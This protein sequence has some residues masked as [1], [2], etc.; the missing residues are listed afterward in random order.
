MLS[1][2]TPEAPPVFETGMWY[3]PPDP[4]TQ[5]IEIQLLDAVLCA[6]SR[7]AAGECGADE[8]SAAIKGLTEFVLDGKLPADL[9]PE[10]SAGH[11]KAAA[12]G[13][14]AG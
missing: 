1:T 5:K 12:T 9:K 6:R 14:F 4:A 2:A 3:D 10:N 13:S 7:Y 11:S 8:Y